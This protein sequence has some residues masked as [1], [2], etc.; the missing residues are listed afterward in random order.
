MIK[1]QAGFTVI[2]LIVVFSIIAILSVIGVASF[3]S[4]SR[5]QILE[6]ASQD[7]LSTLLTAKSR[8]ISQVKPTAQIP[9]CNDSAILNG[10]KVILCPTSSSDVLCDSPNS[11]VLAVTCST[12]SYKLKS[13][14]FPK[15]V[16]YSPVPSTLSFFFPVISSGVTGSGTIT[17]SA[18]GN[19]KTIVVDPIGGIQTQ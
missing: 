17:L 1:N 14:T 5:V 18:Y 11:F 19:T 6:S 12:Q 4:Y 16:T 8:A 9:Q 2:E 15:N 7:L 3:V 10:Y 13:S